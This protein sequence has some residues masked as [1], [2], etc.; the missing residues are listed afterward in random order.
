MSTIRTETRR[1]VA[2]ILRLRA[3]V[4]SLEKMPQHSAVLI[5]RLRKEYEVTRYHGREPTAPDAVVERSSLVEALAAA[6]GVKQA[7]E[8]DSEAVTLEPVWC[9]QHRDGW[10]ARKHNK[11]YRSG[12]SVPTLCDHFVTFPMG[13]EKRLPD[14][15]E[16]LAVMEAKRVLGK[17]GEE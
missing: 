10:C 17:D 3:I 12:A 1:L 11:R 9:I 6:L 8:N 13:C 5:R 14:C 15:P 2:E 4:D 16:C 7:P